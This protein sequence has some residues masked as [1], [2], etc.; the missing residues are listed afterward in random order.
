MTESSFPFP[1]DDELKHPSLWTLWIHH[2]LHRD[3]STAVWV[4]YEGRYWVSAAGEGGFLCVRVAEGDICVY[5]WQWRAAC[6]FTEYV[7]PDLRA[8]PICTNNKAASVLIA[9]GKDCR[10]CSV[11]VGCDRIQDVTELIA[12]N[13]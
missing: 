12:V 4:D 7:L 9:A 11:V 6:A 5:N 1:H 3:E 13:C 2:I 8:N 10:D